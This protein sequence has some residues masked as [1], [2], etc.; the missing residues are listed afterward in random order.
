MRDVRLADR[1]E[2]VVAVV[3]LVGQPEAVLG[4]VR[5]VAV[6]LAAVG[7]DVQAEDAADADPL[8]RAEGADERRRRR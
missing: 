7:G 8:E 1:G 6:G 2:V 3:R 5:D 4:E